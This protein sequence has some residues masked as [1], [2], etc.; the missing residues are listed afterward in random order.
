MSPTGPKTM[1][2][3]PTLNPSNLSVEYLEGLLEDYLRDPSLVPPEWRDFLEEAARA[4]G[5]SGTVRLRPEFPRKSLFGG[6]DTR[7]APTVAA[8][9]ER[10]VEAAA[11][12]SDLQF[13]LAGLVRAFRQWGH[14]AATIDP[15][16]S[17]RPRHPELALEA[18]GLT[19]RDLDRPAGVAGNGQAGTVRQLFEH[20]ERTYC[21]TIG[22]EFMHIDE[23][24]P[25]EWLRQ[26]M[27][28]HENR[29]EL[30][31]DEQVRILRKLTEA[32]LFEEFIQKKYL[33]AKSFSL[34]GGEILSPLLRLAIEKGSTVGISEIV[35][36]MAHRGRLNVLAN[37]L[38]KGPRQ[39]FHEFQDQPPYQS[40][41]GDVKYHL[42]HTHR[43]LAENGKIVEL[44]LCFNPSHLEFV[45]P[46]AE[47]LMRAKQDRDRD[48][49]REH[50]MV[51]LVH[52]DAAFA[53]EGICQETLNASELPGYTTGGT[54][55]VILNNQIG[56]TT[57]P[58]EGRSTRYA[59]DLAKMLQSPIFHVNGEDPRA[60]AQV[61]DMA[62]DFRQ[63]FHRDVFI[64]VY[65]YRR[66][67]HNETDD[68]SYTQ[69]LLYKAISRRKSV[70]E[71]FEETLL[72]EKI[73]TRE[74]A[75][76][77]PKR[78]HDYLESEYSKAQRGDVFG[79]SCLLDDVWKGYHGGPEPFEEKT[80]TGVEREKLTQL[81]EKLTTVPE[82]FHVHPKLEKFLERRREMGRG[83]RPLDWGG[84]EALALA[85][86]AVEGHRVRLSGQDSCRGTFS[87]RHA[88]LYDVETGAPYTPLQHL[89]D[90]Q[91]PVEV[92]NS[93]LSEAGVLGLEYGYSLE[94]P[95][96]L[97]AW[98]AQFGDFWN[99]AQ[100]IVDQ[101]LASAEEKWSRLSGIVLLL[102]HGHEGQ[103][104]EHSSA[105]LERFLNLGTEDNI[106]VVYPTTP[107]Q[108]F[109]VLRRQMLRKWLKPLVILTP[110]SMLRHPA[111]VSSLDDLTKGPFRRVLPDND[112]ACGEVSRIVMCSGKIY[113]EL[114]EKREQLGRKD[115]ALVRLEQLY[116][117]PHKRLRSALDTCRAGTP[118]YW[119]QEDPEN[120]GA[121]YYLK[122]RFRE[123][124]YDR[125][126]FRT[127]ARAPSASPATGS[128]AIHRRE[129]EELLNRAFSEST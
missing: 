31:R 85:S 80:D 100:V 71:T 121:C 101:F 15:L 86:L 10:R 95:E 11:G 119:V 72:A 115:V 29:L 27:E 110:K 96:C 129:Q 105:R 98:E 89:S 112:L 57:T 74:E 109:H 23:V 76:Q 69:P 122:V 97:V 41:K 40:E 45:N 88:V 12:S 61:V 20:L 1:L 39:I 53:G 62:V 117:F 26:R 91:A 114:L 55:H 116:P 64:D 87:H 65:C 35:L 50:G 66:R 16:G 46:V 103:G 28:S 5:P 104:P 34:E 90:D 14:L 81:M 63:R 19:D 49:T 79:P 7:L 48:S 67:G 73:L 2:Q 43:W 13:R 52:G 126:P 102:P 60:V 127:I 68:P 30:T 106:Q 120:M 33:G 17:P 123:E 38:K 4:D 21:R 70:R 94:Y 99:V 125:Y 118:V 37:I 84:A 22:A 6:A 124:L 8:P 83:E 78:V 36:G 56:F 75:D 9:S 107:A 44:T 42:G 113:Y 47:G 111:A 18:H 92:F 77:I 82:G 32:V 3:R 59:T 25:R 24:E 58:Q 51:I 108:Y 54:L 93:P 128:G